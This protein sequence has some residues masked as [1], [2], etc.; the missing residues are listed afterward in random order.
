[1]PSLKPIDFADIFGTTLDHLSEA[2]LKAIAAEN[3]NYRVLEGAERDAIVLDLLKRIESRRL[4]LVQNEDK[5]RWER[6]W[7]ENLDDF[8]KSG[9]KLEALQPKYIRPGMPVRLFRQF[10]Q[11][12][13]P[14]FESNWYSIYRA[15]FVNKHLAAYD[16]IFEFGCGSG[17]NV[18]YVAQQFPKARV[19][20]LDWAAPSVGIVEALRAKHGFN[21]AGRQFDFFHPDE[22]LDM[23]PGSA[24]FTVGALEQTGTQWKK[25][26]DFLMRKK[27]ACCFHIE[28][29]YEW[30]DHEHSLVDYT[31][32]K[33]HEVRN[34]WRGFP[35]EILELE[36]QGRA[37]ILKTK[38][39]NFGSL[40]IEGYSQ[41]FW[42]PL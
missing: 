3:W 17:F 1:M 6:G 16:N 11:P 10:V 19:V 25:F 2:T 35:G 28:P 23:P 24:I 39:I 38:R 26:L 21:V 12:E 40:V 41:L 34:F 9:G 32:W 5:S 8:E 33:A 42:Q 22:S 30:Y 13:D 36:K 29:I 37:R 15:W 7:G 31:A 20:G 4:T 14:N 27:P 18:A